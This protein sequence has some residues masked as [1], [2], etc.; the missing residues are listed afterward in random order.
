[1]LYYIMYFIMCT[2]FNFNFYRVTFRFNRVFLA[3]MHAMLRRR[4]VMTY[5]YRARCWRIG[6]FFLLYTLRY[7]FLL[8][9]KNVFFCF[10]FWWR[11]FYCDN[12][13]SILFYIIYISIVLCSYHRGNLPAFLLSI[14]IYVYTE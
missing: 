11:R 8:F 5:K 2:I 12:Q 1:M 6:S 7:I 3:F 14:Y 9:E 10:Y 13:L 4:F